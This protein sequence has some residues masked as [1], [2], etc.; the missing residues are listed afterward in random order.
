MKAQT[1]KE[2]T[3]KFLLPNPGME[4]AML[5]ALRALGC[6]VQSQRTINQEDLYLDT[7]DWR[8]FRHDWTLRFSRTAGK[9]HYTLKSLR[10]VKGAPED[11]QEI[12]CAAGG[13]I[14][15]PW[16]L[17]E[18]EILGK[19]SEIIYPR[20][21]LG[22]VAVRARRRTAKVIH[23]D[24]TEAEIAFTSFT[25][26]AEGLQKPVSCRLFGSE[27]ELTKG[28]AATLEAMTKNL[29]AAFT[30]LPFPQSIL[31]AAIER[32]GITFPV[33]NPPPELVVSAADRLDLAVKKLL[34]FQL[35]RL[36]E[37]VPGAL[38]DSDTE[39][40]HQAR[41]A[42][43]RMRS[44]LRLFADA[45][46]KRSADYF[47]GELLWLGSL[48]GAVRDLDVFSLNL[49]NRF[50]NGIALAPPRA[51]SSLL[52]QIQE[53]RAGRL[54]DLIEG[55]SSTRCRI[56]LLRIST[57]AT[58]KPAIHPLAPLA[59]S[60][61]GQIAPGV[62]YGLFNKVIS[63]GGLIL[64][65]PKIRNFHKLRIQFKKLRYASEFF[66]PAFD[67]ALSPF[68]ADAVKIQDC[69]GE[70]QD[71][72]FTKELIVGLLKK[73]RGRVM[74]PRLIFVLGEIH[75]L[76]Q[77]IAR[78]RQAEFKAIWKQFDCAETLLKLTQALGMD[79]PPEA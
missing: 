36:Q 55:L 71:T 15:A 5:D 8:L 12:T 58:R 11:R 78:S 9:A 18:T 67:G 74:A 14:R 17:K 66:N 16:D 43:R 27:I 24:G 77:E 32:L 28:T 76:Q 64:L 51:L 37:N 2:V 53:E 25:F 69:L 52:R 1:P 79:N 29:A 21:L 35:H 6:E 38:A 65:K 3:Y 49:A 4:Q 60:P 34:S 45:V 31:E 41:V 56:F 26:Q 19:I 72:V 54:T 63:R 57:F 73:W 40:V 48:L 62:I 70:L 42:T 10:A 46:P 23:P 50:G 44:L 33:K 39:F 61:V 30:L 47:S 13:N 59:L 7:F 68:I 75:Q 20:R 22:H